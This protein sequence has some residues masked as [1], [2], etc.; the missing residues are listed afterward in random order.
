MSS[1]FGKPH[2]PK[3][4]PPEPAPSPL[5]VNQDVVDLQTRDRLRKKKGRAS[6]LLSVGSNPGGVG[7]KKAL[8][9]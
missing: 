9:T 5:S 4:T 3:P 8:G 6:T 2:I 7:V 1:L